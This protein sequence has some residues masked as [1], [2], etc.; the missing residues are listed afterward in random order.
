MFPSRIGSIL[1]TRLCPFSLTVRSLWH[2]PA[3]PSPTV[4]ATGASR[5]RQK[6]IERQRRLAPVADFRVETVDIFSRC[7]L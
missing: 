4:Q 1:K 5:L 7:R 6:Q 2:Y 3:K